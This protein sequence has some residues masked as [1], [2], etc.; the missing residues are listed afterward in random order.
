MVSRYAIAIDIITEGED[1]SSVMP[2]TRSSRCNSGD[3]L[4]KY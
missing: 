4:L 2:V 1:A 3:W